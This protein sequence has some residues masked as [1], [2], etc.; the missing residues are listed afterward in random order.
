MKMVK[1]RIS[2]VKKNTAPKRPK[3]IIGMGT[4]GLG[5]GARVV[6]ESIEKELEKQKLPVDVVRG[7]GY[8]NVFT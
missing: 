4:C 8:W 6:L 1:K 5:A 3:I 7:K 2:P